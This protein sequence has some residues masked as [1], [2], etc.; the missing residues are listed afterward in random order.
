MDYE[1]KVWLNG[2]YLGSHRGGYT[3]FSFNITQALQD[4]ENQLY[5]RAEDVNS[6]TQPRGK[7]S[8]KEAPDSC[9]YTPT[10]GIWQTVWLETVGDTY[11]QTL[12]ITPNIDDQQAVFECEL[13]GNVNV[14]DIALDITYEGR[15][16]YTQRSR[17]VGSHARLPVYIQEPDYVDDVHHWSPERP[18]LYDVVLTLFKNGVL[19]DQITTYFGMRKIHIDNGHIML[20]NKPYYQ[21]L[22][23][24]QGYWPESLMTPP[25]DEAIQH[26]ILL[27]KKMGFNGARK[28]QKIEDPRYYYWADRLGLLVWGE[29]PSGYE[30]RTEIPTL[31]RNGWNPSIGIITTL[32]SFAGSL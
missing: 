27:T 13:A 22:V 24:D 10:S 28:H 31:R 7:Q 6:C 29:M 3:P 23:L 5:L 15:T 14:T 12:R 20:N 11:F 1:A 16:V 8:W 19:M 17:T 32:V 4:G 21:K 26:D 30:F 25:S 18:N 2:V 9:W